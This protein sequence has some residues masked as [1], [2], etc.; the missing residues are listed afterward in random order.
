[1]TSLIGIVMGSFSQPM[2]IDTN[3]ASLVWLL[4]L[5]AAIAIVYKAT[6]VREIQIR[7][8]AKE[9]AVLFGSIMVF[10]IVAALILYLVAWVVTEQLPKI[11]G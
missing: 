1:M 8:F 4:P 7:P 11:L 9:C 2:P 5:V 10:I 6:K 3:A